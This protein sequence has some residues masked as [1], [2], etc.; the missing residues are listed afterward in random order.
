VLA[1]GSATRVNM[2]ICDGCFFEGV[3]AVRKRRGL[4]RSL[5]G[6]RFA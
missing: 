2:E 4:E 3:P 5:R 1:D 6:R